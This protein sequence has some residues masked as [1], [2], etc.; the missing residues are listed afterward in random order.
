MTVTPPNASIPSSDRLLRATP[1]LS[2]PM[3]DIVEHLLN[4]TQ[5]RFDLQQSPDS[6]PWEPLS[7]CIRSK[8]TFQGSR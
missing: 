6:V 8:D 2:E 3:P 7:E 5:D 4:S 1:E